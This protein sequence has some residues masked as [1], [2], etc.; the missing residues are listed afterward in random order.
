MAKIHE[1]MK[2]RRRLNAPLI[3]TPTQKFSEPSFK[4]RILSQF[5]LRIHMMLILLAVIISGVISNKVLLELDVTWM[6]IRYPIAVCV[7]YGVFFFSIKIWL[8]YIGLNSRSEDEIDLEELSEFEPDSA[9]FDLSDNVSVES[10][11]S[12]TDGNKAVY[13]SGS[14]SSSSGDGSVV[15]F[16]PD[17]DLGDDAGFVVILALAL[18]GL[19][20]FGVFGAGIYMIYQSP[21]ILVEAAFQAALASGLI[22]ATKRIEDGAWADSVLRA[23]WIPFAIVLSLAVAIGWVVNHYLPEAT[24]AAEVLEYLRLQLENMTAFCSDSRDQF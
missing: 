6:L 4:E 18:L 2:R 9:G 15:D 21:V 1:H 8:W 7:A 5:Y 22:K 12:P 24:R 16:L 13:E 10:Y 17:L 11:L 14:T 19:L 23:T 20:L 3:I